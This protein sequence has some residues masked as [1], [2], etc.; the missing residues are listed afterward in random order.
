MERHY[1]SD[2]YALSER[3]KM[4]ASAPDFGFPSYFQGAPFV[5][6]RTNAQRNRYRVRARY[7]YRGLRCAFGPPG[8]AFAA[9]LGDAISPT[10]QPG[11]REAS[12]PTGTVLNAGT[13]IDASEAPSGLTVPDE[14]MEAIF[15]FVHHVQDEKAGSHL[16]NVSTASC[17]TGKR[18]GSRRAAAEDVAG[19]DCTQ[20]ESKQSFAAPE[21]PHD[22]SQERWERS[23]SLAGAQVAIYAT[24]DTVEIAATGVQQFH[25]LDF[26]EP[27]DLVPLG[28]TCQ[29]W[30]SSDLVLGFCER[31]MPHWPS[32]REN[33]GVAMSA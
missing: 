24:G 19:V 5:E 16:G 8:L 7:F 21:M 20:T 12:S 11:E 14:N 26:F 28:L 10:P 3:P 6:K 31:R 2:S 13:P 25:P 17:E 23:D 4:V 29:A 1:R 33:Q 18:W 30:Y 22:I 9:S 15:A 27:S 32:C